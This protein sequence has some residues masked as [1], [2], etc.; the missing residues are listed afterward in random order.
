MVSDLQNQFSDSLLS[1]ISPN[2]LLV[3]RNN[4]RAMELP[5]V[6]EGSTLSRLEDVQNTVDTM[7]D[8]IGNDIYKFVPGKRLTRGEIPQ[9]GENVLFIIEENNRKRYEK[10]KYKK[11]KKTLFKV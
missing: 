1:F 9:P 4:E 6:V 8:Y 5:V 2:H 11:Y 7:I 10:F 3:G